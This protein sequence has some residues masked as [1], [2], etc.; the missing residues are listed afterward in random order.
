MNIT[1][2]TNDQSDRHDRGDGD[3]RKSVGKIPYEKD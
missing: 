2:V 3:I 1:S